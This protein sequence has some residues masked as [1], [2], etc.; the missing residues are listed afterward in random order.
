M[1]GD[2]HVRFSGGEIHPGRFT[3][4]VHCPPVP[5]GGRRHG[6]PV[7][8]K[9]LRS[10]R[11]ELCEELGESARQPADVRAGRTTRQV[12]QKGGFSGAV[13]CVPALPPQN[14]SP[15]IRHQPFGDLS[16]RP[17]PGDEVDGERLP[18][19]GPVRDDRKLAADLAAGTCLQA[20]RL[21]PPSFRADEGDLQIR[22][23]RQG[24]AHGYPDPSRSGLRKVHAV[25][26]DPA[27]PA[28]EI[29]V[30]LVYRRGSLP[31]R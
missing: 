27:A 22:P 16:E 5:A 7:P 28:V 13:C 12:G 20:R 26:P 25:G 1:S 15:P 10:Q 18:P 3:L 23:L 11:F 21:S 6:L 2:V 9:M 29:E 8:R 4:G 24:I 19:A 14:S 31:A 17:S 30:D